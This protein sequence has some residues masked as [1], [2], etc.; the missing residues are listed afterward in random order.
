MTNALY[1]SKKFKTRSHNRYWWY[2]SSGAD[3]VPLVFSV[4]QDDEWAVLEEWFDDSETRYD[5]TGEC[6]IPPLS[7]LYG[8]INGNNISRIVQLGHFI[9]F[10][11]LVLGFAL[12]AMGHRQALFSIDIDPSCTGY[13]SGWVDK[14]GLGEQVRLTVSDSA[15]ADMPAQARAYLDGKPQLVF[16]DSSHQ[17]EHTLRELDLWFD[18]LAPGGLLV[19][20]DASPFA[21]QYDAAQGGGVIAAL[22]EWLSRRGLAGLAVNEFCDGTQPV[23]ALTYRDACGLAII[24][25]PFPPARRAFAATH[26]P[27]HFLNINQTDAGWYSDLAHRA[28][29]DGQVCPARMVPALLAESPQRLAGYRYFTGH[30]GTGL[31]SLLEQP[32]E[33]LVLLRDPIERAVAQFKAHLGNPGTEFHAAIMAHGGDLARCLDDPVLLPV[34]ADYQTRFLA[35]P[36]DLKALQADPALPRP[37]IQR[38]LA[39]GTARYAAADLLPAAL[40]VLDGAAAI[41]VRERPAAAARRLADALDEPQIRALSTPEN[42][43]AAAD[44]PPAL[45]RRLEDLNRCD[46]VLYERAL[47]QS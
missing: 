14:A 32:P 1:R 29:D 45:Q 11:T 16:I 24:Q 3:Y 34:L 4:L 2:R 28:F 7:L 44:L 20:H 41:G 13:A 15:A 19:L 47:Q 25:K 22:R 10:S 5:S 37:G 6:N 30:F 40:A 8:L 39:D 42:P 9:G 18:H 33:S 12:R 31:A 23:E 26:R 21:A 17:Y 36:V 38:L 27:L 46:L 35:Q 43:P